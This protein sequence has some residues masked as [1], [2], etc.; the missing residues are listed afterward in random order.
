MFRIF[1]NTLHHPQALRRAD[2]VE[3]AEGDVKRDW[4]APIV[5]DAEAG[6]GGVL[7]AYELMKVRALPCAQLPGSK[8]YNRQP[9]MQVVLVSCSSNG[10]AGSGDLPVTLRIAYLPQLAFCMLFAS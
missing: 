6:F 5:A 7:N 2:Q 10:V 9:W 4:Y 3:S 8:C 1:Y